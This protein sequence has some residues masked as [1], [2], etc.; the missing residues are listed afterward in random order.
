MKASL[1]TMIYRVG[2]FTNGRIRGG[3]KGNGLI[4]RCMVT[5][6]RLGRMEGFIKEVIRMIGKMV[7]E[8]IGGQMAGAISEVGK[9]VSNTVRANSLRNLVTRELVFGIKVKG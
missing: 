4:I 8:N 9:A 1:L 6:R 2:V 7:K 3:L 5:G